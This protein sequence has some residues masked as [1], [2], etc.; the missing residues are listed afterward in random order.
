MNIKNQNNYVEMNISI[1]F[2]YNK[3]IMFKCMQY[4][5]NFINLMLF[6]RWSRH[7]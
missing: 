6:I 1:Y 5:F 4:N 3:K 2:N 7:F